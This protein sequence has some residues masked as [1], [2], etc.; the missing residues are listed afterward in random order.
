MRVVKW[1]DVKPDSTG[2]KSDEDD[3]KH[4]TT[5]SSL[6]QTPRP[7]KKKVIETE[8]EPPYTAIPG[9]ALDL[10]L[11]FNVIADF[12]RYQGQIN[13]VYFKDTLVFQTR[14]YR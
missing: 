10:D 7:T 9:S 12:A 14:M 1:I 2:V 8:P 3:R 13:K 6:P 4:R 11:M 5:V